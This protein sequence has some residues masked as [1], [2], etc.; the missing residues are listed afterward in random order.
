MS[1]L[2]LENPSDSVV[3]QLPNFWYSASSLFF[4]SIAFENLSIIVSVRHV[5][6]KI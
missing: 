6:Q 3:S 1:L 2:G 5:H 4:I